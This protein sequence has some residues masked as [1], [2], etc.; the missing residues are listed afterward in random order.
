M[1]ED[2][3]SSNLPDSKILESFKD[4]INKSEMA[5]VL[6]ELFD[7]KKLYMIGDLS[8]REIQ[9][10]TKILVISKIKNIG[11]MKDGV[12][13]FMTLLISKDRRSRKELLEAIRGYSSQMSFLQKV[14]PFNKKV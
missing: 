5:E 8:R 3:Y 4:A 9:L 10:A 6:K 12:R 11:I 7:E 1:V 14:N 13:I 2:G